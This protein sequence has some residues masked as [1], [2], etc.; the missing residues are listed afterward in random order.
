MN[1]IALFSAVLFSSI[2]ATNVETLK[3]GL[4]GIPGLGGG[5]TIYSVYYLPNNP[6]FILE[7]KAFDLGYLN[8]SDGSTYV[9]YRGD[10]YTKLSDAEIATLKAM[11]GFDP[12]TE[13]RKN[14]WRRDRLAR[15]QSLLMAFFVLGCVYW[16]GLHVLRW[17]A[18][19]SASPASENDSSDAVETPVVIRKKQL[20]RRRLRDTQ[21]D[22]GARAPGQAAVSTSFTTKVP[23]RTFGRRSA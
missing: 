17:I 15:R 19:L 18:R 20:L 3:A 4:F 12:T 13:Y 6:P 9:L 21:T 1:F 2:S 11:L 7:G 22:H 10:R 5:E 8:S 14:Q 16:V 23:V